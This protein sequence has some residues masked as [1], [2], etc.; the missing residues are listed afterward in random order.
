[1][2]FSKIDGFEVTP[3]R[4]SRSISARKLALLR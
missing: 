2:A 3:F 4:P 1:M